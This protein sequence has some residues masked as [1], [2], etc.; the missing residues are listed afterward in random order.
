MATKIVFVAFLSLIL[1]NAAYGGGIGIY[2]GQGQETNLNQTC[3]TKLYSH[4]NIGFLSTFGNGKN[5]TLNLAKHCNPSNGGCGLLSNQIKYCQSVGVK[6]FLSI[7]GNAAGYASL[8]SSYEAR[9]LANYLWTKFL[10]GNSRSRPLGNVV[11]DGVDFYIE[12]GSTKYYDLLARYLASYSTKTKKVYLS[13]A[14]QCSYPD[15]YLNVALNTGLF[16]YVW[17]RF[18]NNPSCEYTTKNAKN[19]FKAWNYWTSI[20]ANKVFLGLPASPKATNSGFIPVNVL[21]SQVLPV[22]KKSP[23]YGGVMLWSRYWDQ[24][25]KYSP[26]IKNYA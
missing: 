13:A 17:V 18:N 3:S 16:D 22:I 5:P 4:V 14:P 10:G 26:A 7:S 19:F 8:N 25:G 20:K 9:I 24:I 6:V 23:K 21:K 11:L 15:K 1:A 2:W 12:S